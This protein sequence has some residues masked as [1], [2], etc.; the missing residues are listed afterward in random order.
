[1]AVFYKGDAVEM[2]KK[3]LAD[4]SIDLIYANPPFDGATKNSWDR[5]VDWPAFFAEAFRVL[6]PTG[7]LVLHCSVPFNYTLI[8]SA[9]KPPTYSW[10]W[11]KDGNTNPLIAKVQPLRNTEEILVWKGKKAPYYPQ[12]VGTEE[13][14]FRSQ[15]AS[16]YYGATSAQ[17]LQTVKG[18]YQTH[19]ID[20]KR[21]V[22]GFSTR[23]RALIELIYNSYTTEG[24]VV[25]DPFCYNGLS[26]TCCPGRR[27]I[28]TDLIH[29][30]K[31]LV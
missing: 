6:K 12:R 21:E 25:Y 15:G 22:D 1:M 30:P 7:Y 9:P 10:Y 13:R 19:H 27:W 26:S 11:L 3:H 16:S 23:P 28:G 20:M 14:T 24:S 8:R 17:P 4:S 31:Y 5:V 2:M 29:I 18:F